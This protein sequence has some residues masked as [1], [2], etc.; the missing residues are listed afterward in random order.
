MLMSHFI[1][2]TLCFPSRLGD[3]KNKQ[4]NRESPIKH[5]MTHTVS[6]S[7]NRDDPVPPQSRTADWPEV[8][9]Q[10]SAAVPR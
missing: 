5:S 2:Q 8:L 3:L 7:P 1:C 4:S 9:P 10:G 6:R